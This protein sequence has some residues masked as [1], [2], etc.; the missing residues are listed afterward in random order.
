M[1]IGTMAQSSTAIPADHPPGVRVVKPLQLDDNTPQMAG[2]RRRAGIS[3]DL[4]GSERIWAGV[5]LAEPNTASPVHHHGHVETVVYVVTG[6]SRLR[7]G[8]RLEHEEELE[9]GD[10]A[11]IPP[12]M[13][14]QEL[15]P[16]PDRPTQWIVV[17]SAREA[18]IVALTMGPDGEYRSG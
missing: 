2:M 13:P 11:F 18:V 9:P 8:R 14:H 17:R 1:R 12:Y 6:R 5:L 4:V 3:N 16:S 15:N 7:W 10:F